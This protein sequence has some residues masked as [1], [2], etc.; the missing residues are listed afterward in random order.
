MKTLTKALTLAALAVAALN[1]PAHAGP[2]D[3]G[4]CTS[5]SSLGN[6]TPPDVA[7]FGNSF[8]AP[9]NFNDC[10]SFSLDSG[11]DALGLTIEWDLSRIMSIDLSSVSIWGSGPSALGSSLLPGNTLNGFQFAGLGAGAYTLSVTGNVGGV[12]GLSTRGNSGSVGYFG[13][14]AT[15]RSAAV[16]EPGTLALLGLGLAGVGLARRRRKAA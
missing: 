14:L 10:Y 1:A 13:I 6:L 15:Q 2:M 9:T 12:N 16:P 11:A 8:P 3:S 7:G 4:W 5:S